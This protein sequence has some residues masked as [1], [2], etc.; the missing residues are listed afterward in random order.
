MPFWSRGSQPGL[1]VTLGVHLIIWRGTIIVQLQQINL[2]MK[3][4]SIFVVL[5]VLKFYLWH[6]IL[7]RL[8]VRGHFRGTCS[9]VRMLKVYMV[10]E[11]LVISLLELSNSKCS[12][13]RKTSYQCAR[14]L[15]DT[16]KTNPASANC[17]GTNGR[18]V[19]STWLMLLQRSKFIAD[20]IW[21]F[22]LNM[23]KAV[24]SS[25]NQSE[26]DLLFHLFSVIC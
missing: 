4:E 20:D 8:F 13:Q 6:C 16:T 15:P 14:W 26:L 11:R 5:K 25:L 23:N 2:H 19:V 1:R 7:L 12:N 17:R 3:T 9:S 21:T 18:Y 10:R 22:K 24:N